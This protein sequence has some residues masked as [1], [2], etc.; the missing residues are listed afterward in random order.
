MKKIGLVF[1]LA[2][3]LGTSGGA[4]E[5]THECYLHR[6][7][8]DQNFGDVLNIYGCLNSNSFRYYNV[9]SVQGLQARINVHIV[10]A[11]VPTVTGKRLADL[12]VVI[13]SVGIP[14]QVLA[15]SP[16]VANAVVVL[17]WIPTVSGTYDL[18][19]STTGLQNTDYDGAT[20]GQYNLFLTQL[21][22]PPTP[23]PI[24]TI[25]RSRPTPM[26]TPTPGDRGTPTPTPRPRTR[27]VGFR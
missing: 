11:P 21:A 10:V 5:K 12:Q 27:V 18:F 14:P 24:P 2:M 7:L 8:Y 1:I 19:V 9:Y 13:Q 20:L 23:T 15:F 25:D 3:L 17:D 26:P 16:V 4:E 6:F 22:L